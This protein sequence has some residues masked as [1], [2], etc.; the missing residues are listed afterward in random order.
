MSITHDAEW[1]PCKLC[2]ALDFFR[3]EI[4]GHIR[5]LGDEPRFHSKQWEYA[6]VLETRRRY[7]PGA[8]RIVGL[9]C[10]NEPIIPLV[11]AGA[12]EVIV[13]DLYDQPGRWLGAPERPD[14]TYRHMKNLRVHAMDMRQADLPDEIADFI[15]TICA[16]GCV[17]GADELLRTVRQ[18][19]RL[20]TPGGV[21][22]LTNVFTFASTPIVVPSHPGTFLFLDR[23]L[24]ERLFTETGLHLVAPL[25]LRI[26]SHPFN[27]PLARALSERHPMLPHVCYTWRRGFLRSMQAT[28]VSMALGREDRG[29]DRILSDPG[30]PDRLK[31]LNA[32]AQ[33]VNRRL[34]LPHEWMWA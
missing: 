34:T 12:D 25:D 18:I 5:S 14:T 4:I 24:V 21:L 13:T 9:G 10:A 1:S 2:D 26:S 30:Q 7:A 6:Q 3:P 15:W 16:L 27:A 29:A 33:R 22:V 32:A 28:C 11:G 19:G 17:G 20:L 8:K 23:G 31:D